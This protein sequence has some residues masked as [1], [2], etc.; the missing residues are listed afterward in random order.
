MPR[1]RRS[2]EAQVTYP[3]FSAFF[4]CPDEVE[5]HL[6]DPQRIYIR[7]EVRTP[8]LEANR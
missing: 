7:R 2:C 6:L 3:Y 1:R 5:R 4:S 8:G